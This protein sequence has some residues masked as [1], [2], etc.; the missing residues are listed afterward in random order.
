MATPGVHL[1]GSV[2]LP[3]AEAVFRTVSAAVGPYLHRIPDGET[4]E[5]VRWIWFQRA[6]RRAVIER[7]DK[8][9]TAS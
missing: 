2:P 9:G 3:D 5:R 4:G 1:I 7:I 6:S 8:E